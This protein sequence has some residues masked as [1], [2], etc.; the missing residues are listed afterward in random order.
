M[1][2]FTTNEGVTHILI[3]SFTVKRFVMDKGTPHS[4][5]ARAHKVPPT[6]QYIK[7]SFRL[8]LLS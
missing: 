3:L 6:R 8:I 1:Y 2:I 5:P 4:T 7:L